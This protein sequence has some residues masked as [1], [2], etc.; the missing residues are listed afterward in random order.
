MYTSCALYLWRVRR[1]KKSALYI[2][3]YITL[4]LSVETIFV[5]VQARTVQ[6]VYIDNRNYPGGPW[7]Y[8][9]ATQNLAINV[10]FYAT[11]FVLTFLSDILVVRIP[12]SF[13]RR[14]VPECL[15]LLSQLW[16]CWVIWMSSGRMYATIVTAV[17]GVMLL[18]SFGLGFLSVPHGLHANHWFVVMGTLWTLQS[19]QPGLSLYSALPMAYGTSYYAISLGVNI[20]LTI[21]ITTRLVLYR[22]SIMARLPAE[23]A[24]HYVSLAA[25]IVESAAIYS[26]FAILFLITYAVNNP[27][28]QVLLAFASA[29]QVGYH[30]VIFVV[31][32]CV[33]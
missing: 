1:E 11:L 17:P 20:I 15:M 28:N 31:I 3:A 26:V 10:M 6:V 22:R 7:A 16:R 21:L 32:I 25:I 30:V 9:L 4:L 24:S 23:Y 13:L 29:A 14:M 2:L 12:P 33:C 5:A 27:T 19:S 8:F 18:G